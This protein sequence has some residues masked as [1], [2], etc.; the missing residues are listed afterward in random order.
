MSFQDFQ[1]SKPYTPAPVQMPGLFDPVAGGKSMSQ[2]GGLADTELFSRIKNMDGGLGLLKSLQTPS[3]ELMKMRQAAEKAKQAQDPMNAPIIGGAPLSPVSQMMV[4][5]PKAPVEDTVMAPQKPAAPKPTQSASSQSVM[6]SLMESAPQRVEEGQEEK[7]EGD[8]ELEAAREEERRRKMV[9]GIL[10]SISGGI[11][12]MT[13]A[14]ASPQAFNAAREAA[15]GRVKSLLDERKLAEQERL[16]DPNSPESVR[17][18]QAI[19]QTIGVKLPENFS[20]ADYDKTGGDL[21]KLSASIKEKELDRQNIMDQKRLATEMEMSKEQR[22]AQKEMEQQE[23]ETFVVGA[24]KFPTKEDRQKFLDVATDAIPALD[25]LNRM[26][27]ILSQKSI[28]DPG[29][30]VK[31][32]AEADTLRKT[33]MG[34]LREPVTGPGILNDAERQ[35]LLELLPDPS[36]IF[37]WEPATQ[38]RIKAM[39]DMLEN[40]IK[41]EAQLRGADVT[42]RPVSQQ[43]QQ[44]RPMAFQDPEKQKRYEELKRK[45]QEAQNANRS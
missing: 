28:T 9:T 1:A 30:L 39:K 15:G 34:K 10:E 6:E 36:S 43:Y 5:A 29:E 24:G 41:R 4:S 27:K 21:V 2:G 23:R 31:L 16:K 17:L 35:M 45:Q 26:E 18:R 22:A 25:D 33:L 7:P 32:R 3:S 38:T 8:L 20:Y 40:A 11:G 37:Q 19:E 42:Y 13:G 12:A 14:Q 44:R